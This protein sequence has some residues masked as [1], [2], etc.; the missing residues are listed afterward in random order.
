MNYL[1]VLFKNKERKKI[2]N[3]FVT[4]ERAKLFYDEK[5]K[6]SNQVEFEVNVEN[7]TP[8]SYELALVEKKNNKFESLYVKD[9]L[10][11]QI[12]INLDD[13]NYRVMSLVKFNV[14]EKLYDVNNKEKITFNGFVKNYLKK[15]SVKLVSKLNNKVVLQDNDEVK[16]FSLKDVDESHRFLNC[17]TNHLI[18]ENRMD[19]IVVSD[20]SSA[21]KKYLYD[22]LS[23]MGIDKKLLYRTTT[24][25]KP[26]K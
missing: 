16:L 7:A 22:I 25:F 13:E 23:N 12:K 24:T 21:Q 6:Q 2:I 5:I 8:C 20:T 17:L 3:K 9:S 18:N 1:I 4:Y 15:G 19:V 10:G 14:E 11:R 26:R